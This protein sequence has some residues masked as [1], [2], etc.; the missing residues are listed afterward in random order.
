MSE[1]IYIRQYRPSDFPQIRA[2]L[3]EGFVTSQG[4]VALVAQ[5]RFLI[6]PPSLIAY[7]LGGIGLGLLSRSRSWT[8]PTA[9]AGALLCA[10]GLA[11]LTAIQRAIPK[12]MAAFCEQALAADMRDI[13]AHYGAPAVFFVAAQPRD[14]TKEKAEATDG[15]EEVVGYVGLEYLPEKDPHTAEVRRMIVAAA[16]RRRGIAVRLMRAVITH[17]ETI[18]GLRAIELG[19]SEYQD[20]A[21]RL[22][23]QLG[24]VVFHVETVWE[25]LVSATI[26]HY[27]RPVGAEAGV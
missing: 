6:K 4:S 2:L 10:A 21:R 12:A 3:F 19:T 16:H 18:P 14:G 13:S 17:G 27:R 8:S 26:H 22:Y 5:R 24:W 23:E 9:G 25:R 20:G 11:L 15:E 7:L 1:R